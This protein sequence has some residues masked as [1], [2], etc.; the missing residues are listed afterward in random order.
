MPSH[1][2]NRHLESV[3]KLVGIYANCVLRIMGRHIN[4]LCP[5]GSFSRF[6]TIEAGKMLAIIG[7]I[8]LV[9][10]LFVW[11]GHMTEKTY[12][13][14]V[15]PHHPR[16]AEKQYTTTQHY[17]TEFIVGLCV[18]LCGLLFIGFLVAFLVVLPYYG[19]QEWYRDWKKKEAQ[20]LVGVQHPKNPWFP[21]GSPAKF[22]ATVGLW[23][24]GCGVGLWILSYPFMYV[25]WWVVIAS[26]P[27]RIEIYNQNMINGGIEYYAQQFMLYVVGLCLC[28]FFGIIII[29]TF[30]ISK[31]GLD[32][33]KDR[34]Q[35]YREFHLSKRG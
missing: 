3:K 30:A 23:I 10:L 6:I 9:C 20:I 13:D 24:V 29:G 31:Y 27:K 17:G 1:P 34:W 7:S 32:G 12:P 28:V 33:L 21:I 18:G 15:S 19:I 8:V 35:R 25:T 2:P 5:H 16:N 22:A 11:I 26:H 4:R 14:L